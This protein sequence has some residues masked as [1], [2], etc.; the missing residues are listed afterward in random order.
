MSAQIIDG[1]AM[2]AQLRAQ[3]KT[4]VDAIREAGGCVPGLAVV[5]VGEDP[6]S[7]IYVR[8][9]ERACK[10]VGMHSEVYRLPA[11]TSQVE[12]L[13]LID[14]LNVD[15][16]IHGILVQSPPPKHIDESAVIRAIN[17]D[18]DVDGF[19]VIN[20]GRLCTGQP[21]LVSCTPKGVIHL[22]KS[23]G[24]EIC[25][26][27][28]VVIGRSNIVGKPVAQLLLQENAT[29]IQC[30]SR[31]KNLAD[32]VRLGDIVV[33][34][35]GKKN[36]I[37]ADM[38]KP[39]AVVIDVGMNRTEDGLFGDVDFEAASEVAGYITPVP[40]GAGPMTIAMLLQNTLEAAARHV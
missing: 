3:I 10:A 32:M 39:G 37:T 4:R 2:A 29:V 12:L 31:T 23:T 1:K 40:G 19:H 35:V 30:H 20:V 15:P 9:K 34:A 11:Q 21:G 14:R 8:N 26:K 18:K 16:A 7:Q 17:P 22:I 27:V 6:A 38:I 33:A 36:I 28:A 5:L 25:G 13:A 24:V